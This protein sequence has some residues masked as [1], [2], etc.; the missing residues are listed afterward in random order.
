MKKNKW[1]TIGLVLTLALVMIW[2]VPALAQGRRGPWGQGGQ[3]WGCQGRGMGYYS[4]GQGY[5]RGYYGTCPNYPGYQSRGYWGNNPQANVG[6]RGP[7]GY[8]RNYQPNPKANP[9]ATQ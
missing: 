4:Q 6:P 7:R 1:L 2:V 3:G 8:G 9:P 5:G